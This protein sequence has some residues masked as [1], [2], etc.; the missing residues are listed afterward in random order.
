[1]TKII[2]LV[3]TNGI[4]AEFDTR[5]A[6]QTFADNNGAFVAEFVVVL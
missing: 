4:V 3:A 6:A 5:E 1:M 2:Y